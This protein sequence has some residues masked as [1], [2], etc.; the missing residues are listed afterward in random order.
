MEA[1]ENSGS[2]GAFQG[3]FSQ[4]S[5]AKTLFRLILDNL[6]YCIKKKACSQKDA[7][8]LLCQSVLNFQVT[9]WDKI[10]FQNY[11]QGLFKMHISGEPER[12][13]DLTEDGKAKEFQKKKEDGLFASD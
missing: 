5:N 12:P 1:I 10:N 6:V 8:A 4:D 7:E 3:F 13:S 11:L 2:L 9:D